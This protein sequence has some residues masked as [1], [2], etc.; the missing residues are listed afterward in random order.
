MDYVK[1]QL[2]DLINR[3]DAGSCLFGELDDKT[4]CMP[5][6]ST[7]KRCLTWVKLCSNLSEKIV[8]KPS[9]RFDCWYVTSNNNHYHQ[10]KLSKKG[11]N[12]KWLTH[13]LTYA[14]KNPGQMERLKSDLH[15]SHRCGRGRSVKEIG[16]S[17][18]INPYHLI[19][20]TRK[21][22]ESQKGCKYGSR[23]LCPHE[24][25]CLYTSEDTGKSMKCFNRSS[26]T[27]CKLKR[28]C[29]HL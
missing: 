21:I 9:S 11:G 2:V 27:V 1:T 26:Y 5:K 14:L 24:K 16:G 8:N 29:K 6:E 23:F 18:C 25:K 13:R 20:T 4:L 3:L 17:V 15:V 28:R 12:N 19:L 7:D 10:T 22:N